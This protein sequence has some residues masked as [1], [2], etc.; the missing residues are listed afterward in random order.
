[1]TG[2]RTFVIVGM[3]YTLTAITVFTLGLV[4]N[5]DGPFWHLSVKK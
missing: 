4:S 5:T 3:Q 1:M 2:E